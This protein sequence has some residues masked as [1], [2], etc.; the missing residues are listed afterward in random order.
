MFFF[1]F[2][3]LLDAFFFFFLLHIRF[4]S[5]SLRSLSTTISIRSMAKYL[6]LTH[7]FFI[8]ACLTYCSTS[9]DWAMPFH[10]FDSATP[11]S[12]S[13]LLLLLFFHLL[14]LIANRI[15]IFFGPSLEF[16]SL[17]NDDSSRNY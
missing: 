3:H 9:S 17:P 12:P 14:I 13:I 15:S 4:H 6:S 11:P 16:M 8:C 5:C 7:L 1:S 10:F 2:W